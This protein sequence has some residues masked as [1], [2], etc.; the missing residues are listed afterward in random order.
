MWI[1]ASDCACPWCL[2]VFGERQVPNTRMLLLA[3]IGSL[4]V[5][6]LSLG[7]FFPM[8]LG[9]VLP[10]CSLLVILALVRLLS[11]LGVTKRLRL[12]ER[13]TF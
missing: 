12:A 1:E 9:G 10:R 2:V 11:P 13:V 4:Q 7:H 3:R 6:H 5:L 8:L